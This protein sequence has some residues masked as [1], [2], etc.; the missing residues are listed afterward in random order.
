MTADQSESAPET[1]T[2]HSS[3]RLYQ[4]DLFPEYKEYTTMMWYYGE[5]EVPAQSL[6]ATLARF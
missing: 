4:F 6:S 1:A 3:T 5:A 2:V